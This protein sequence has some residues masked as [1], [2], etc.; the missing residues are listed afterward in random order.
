[1]LILASR[2]TTT[3]PRTGGARAGRRP[4]ASRRAVRARRRR[5]SS[6]APRSPPA[7]PS[8]PRTP[9]HARR[10]ASRSPPNSDRRARPQEL[11][12]GSSAGCCL[13][14]CSAA[15]INLGF[16][17]QHRGLR[18]RPVAT[19][20]SPASCARI[21][22]PHMARRAGARLA[23]VRGADRRGRDRAAVARP[24]VRRGRAGAV[25]AAGRGAVRAADHSRARWL[26]VLS[27]AAALAILPLGLSAGRDRL[28]AGSLAGAIAIG[29]VAAS[30]GQHGPRALRRRS[31]PGSSTASPTPRSR[32]SRSP[33][34]AT[35]RRGSLRLDGGRIARHARRLPRL[36]GG[37]AGR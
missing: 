22:Q 11:A 28:A 15:L 14:S 8:P 33:C 12:A 17:L 7:P 6:P 21:A 19:G 4:R 23:R 24:G 27:I 29:A 1:M 36:P 2:D 3:R 37:A 18:A 10:A 31:R 5:R 13:R 9:P 34:D 16:L 26:A 20:G 25:G 30:R 35:A 32:R